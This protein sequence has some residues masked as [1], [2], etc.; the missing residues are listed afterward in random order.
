[1]KDL[2]V[3]VVDD[4]E[5]FVSALVERLSLRGIYAVG[6]SDG[7]QA[8]ETVTRDDFNIVI[9]DLKMPGVDG[10]EILKELLAVQPDLKIFIITGYGST[11][12]GEDGLN[13]GAAAYLPKPI[14]I[15][16]LIDMMR[17]SLEK[18]KDS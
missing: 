11:D 6:I 7:T 1:M 8:V 12:L 15:G 5:E 18:D 4:E 9:L 14:K 13:A 3:L 2:K 17:E 10:L 16:E